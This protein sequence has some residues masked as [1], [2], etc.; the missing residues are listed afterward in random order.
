MEKQDALCKEYYGGQIQMFLATA[1][2]ACLRSGMS[3]F[4]GSYD[5]IP[6]VVLVQ[7]IVDS[8]LPLLQTEEEEDVPFN[9]LV[10]ACNAAPDARTLKYGVNVLAASVGN[11]NYR[12]FTLT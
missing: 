8:P 6:D 10:E 9:A 12:P 1:T 4:D 3:L 7:T 5:A 2:V 11:N